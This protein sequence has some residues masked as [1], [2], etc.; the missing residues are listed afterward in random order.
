MNRALGLVVGMLLIFAVSVGVLLYVL[1]AP[2]KPTDYLV[3]GAIGTLLCLVLL[4]VVLMK[5]ASKGRGG[6]S[7][8]ES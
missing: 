2:H 3:T 4:F 1:P 5:T 8:S 7:G 6:S